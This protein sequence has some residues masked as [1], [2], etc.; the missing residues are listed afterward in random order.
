[1]RKIFQAIAQ[2]LLGTFF[3]LLLLELLCRV[4]GFPNGANSYVETIVIREKLTSRKPADEFRIFAYGESTMH[5][6]HYWPASNPARWLE[7]YLKDFLPGRKIRIV[8]FARMGQGSDF[9]QR[10]V[11]NTLIYKPDLI[12]L[13]AGHNGFLPGN[14]FDQVAQKESKLSFKFKLWIR[15]SAL[16]SAAIRF[17]IANKLK[18]NQKAEEDQIGYEQIETPPTGIGGAENEFLRDSDL[19]NKNIAHHRANYEEILNVAADRHIPI[20]IFKPAS[21][22]KDYPPSC[23]K[24]RLPLSKEN[25]AVWQGAYEEGRKKQALGDTRGALQAYEKAYALGQAHADLLY[26]MGQLLMKNGELEK[27]RQFLIE[28]KDED[29]IIV[30]APSVVENY[31]E[32]FGKTGKA[33]VIDT[34]KFLVSEAPGGILGDPIVEDNV[35]FSVKGH[36]LLGRAAAQEIAEHGWIAPKTEWQFGRERDFET[37]ARELGV[38]QELIFSAFLKVVS[39]FG[40]K[41]DSRIRYA[42]KALAIHPDHPRGLRHLAWSYWLKGDHS[43]AFEIY[44]KLA[45]Q[46]PDELQKA[47]YKNPELQKAFQEH[48]ALPAAA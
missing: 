6:S 33:V 19:Y 40:S 28:A 22:L 5:G 12:L 45:K 32:A 30:R 41:F 23:S 36:A 47:F 25:E 3:L 34:E 11:K 26:R 39:Y 7:A 46:Y 18:R 2:T 13:Y 15:N 43:Q 44:E 38:T 17:G 42:Q 31:F 48:I 4:A 29:C 35:H 16:I 10:S 24:H 8:N 37:L 9:I 14:R 21:N 27:A 1:M 20:L